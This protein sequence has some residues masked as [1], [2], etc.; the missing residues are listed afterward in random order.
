V[1]PK[2]AA[3]FVYAVDMAVYMYNASY[4]NNHINSENLTKPTFCGKN[5]EGLMV[6]QYCALNG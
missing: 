5:A 2:Q 1:S 3:F 6:K 4:E